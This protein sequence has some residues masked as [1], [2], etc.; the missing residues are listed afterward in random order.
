MWQGLIITVVVILW[1]VLSFIDAY[2]D[3]RLATRVGR[4]VVVGIAAIS[5][6][7]PGAFAAGTKQFV[8]AESKVLTSWLTRSLRDVLDWPINVLVPTTPSTTT[9]TTTTTT[10][11]DPSTVGN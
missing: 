7:A 9:T 10:T 6:L 2:L 1:K 5:W 3:G 11:S 4:A 8:D